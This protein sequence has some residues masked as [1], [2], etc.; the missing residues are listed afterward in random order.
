M[1]QQLE[2]SLRQGGNALL[3]GAIGTQLQAMAVPMDNTA[4]AAKALHTHPDTV[5]MMHKLYLDCGVDIITTNTYSSARHNLEP[6]GLGDLTREL[7]YRAVNLAMEAR[8]R[9][10]S[11]RNVTLAG[12]ISA[13]GLT[14]G[15]ESVRSLHRHARPRTEITERQARANLREQSEILAEAGVDFLLLEGTGSL[16]HRHWMVEECISTGLPLW[17]GFRCRLDPE[18]DTPRI[19]YSSETAFADGLAEFVDEGLAGVAIFH[20]TID[21][22]DAAIPVAQ[23]L[24]SGPLAVYPEADRSDYTLP[25]K[26]ENIQSNVTP[27]EYPGIAHK[28]I[29]QGVHVVGGCCGINLD[30]YRDLK[31]AFTDPASTTT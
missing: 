14:L 19:G 26:D 23:S 8:E 11:D 29:S 27:D 7:N 2:N 9:F 4:W 3:D 1:Y 20:S 12:S 10:A 25:Y 28:W 17:L 5:R 30:Y 31:Q 18:D 22:T 6:L 21:A 24:W 16:T 13:F 15:G